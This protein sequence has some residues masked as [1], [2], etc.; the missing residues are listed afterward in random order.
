MRCVYQQSYQV[1]KI[2][3][4]HF[5]NNYNKNSKQEF[6]VAKL[7]SRFLSILCSTGSIAANNSLKLSNDALVLMSDLLD[8]YTVVE[9]RKRFKSESNSE[10]LNFEVFDSVVFRLCQ[11]RL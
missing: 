9:G 1:C 10:F 4:N 7:A 5:K 8:D 2:L 3:V 6:A 11:P